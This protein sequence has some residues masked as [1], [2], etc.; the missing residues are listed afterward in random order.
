MVPPLIYG[1][2]SQDWIH[3]PVS[4]AKGFVLSMRGIDLKQAQ[5]SLRAK[6]TP[7]VLAAMLGSVLVPVLGITTPQTLTTAAAN[8]PNPGSIAV[9][10]D[11]NWG[12]QCGTGNNYLT[13]EVPDAIALS[14]NVAYTIEAWVKTDAATNTS[15]ATLPGCAEI[16]AGNGI[17]GRFGDQDSQEV[18]NQRNAR[19][20]G[21]GGSHY[22]RTAANG[23][24]GACDGASAATCT[25]LEFPNGRWTHIALQKSVVGSDARLTVFIGGKVVQSKNGI[26]SPT[27]PLKVF[28]LGPFGDNA[29][30]KAFYGQMRVSSG[31]IY[32]TDGT[33]AF[34]P[35][36]DFSTTV[37]GG[38]VLAL[39][40]PQ[41]NT[42]P[43]N[44]VDLMNNNTV[45]TTRVGA[46]KIASSSDF[47]VPSFG[48]SG[49]GYV[50]I[51][52]ATSTT[53][54]GC[55]GS[56]DLSTSGITTL[57]GTFTNSTNVTEVTLPN[58]LQIISNNAFVN[59]GIAKLVLPPSITSICEGCIASNAQL[60]SVEMS[61]SPSV[62][63]TYGNRT[64]QNNPVL[65][66]VSF[67]YSADTS[68]NLTSYTSSAT[69]MFQG[70]PR[71][72][73]V[74]SCAA[75][76]S[77]LATFLA[78]VN[79]S[80]TASPK[81]VNTFNGTFNP[82]V[83]CDSGDPITGG[84]TT[85]VGGGN[86]PIIASFTASVSGTSVTLTSG[87][88][89]QTSQGLEAKEWRMS[90]DNYTWSTICYINTDSRNPTN[91][92]R[93]GL[94]VGETYYFRFLQRSYRDFNQFY[95]PNITVT[96]PPASTVATLSNL[97]LSSG[98]LSPAFSSA[99][100]NYTATVD[101][102]VATGYAVTPT[103]TDAGANTVQYLGATGTTAFTGA[104]NIG[105]NV[106]R[107]VVT[108]ADNVT[109]KTYTVTVTRP[110]S[111]V[112]TL[113]GLVLSS[114]T[115]SP[116]FNS[117]TTSYTMSVANSVTS[118]TV[119][120]TRTQANATITVNGTPVNSGSA[121]GAISLNVGTNNITV[122]VT[123]QDG[124]TTGTYTVVVTRAETVITT[125][126]VL[127]TA[128]AVGATP[129]TSTTS[130]GQYTTCLLYTSPSP[131]DRQKSRMPSSA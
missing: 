5:L 71:L 120:P 11:S 98:T 85:D 31:A 21:G 70:N 118:T 109:T 46:S 18:W 37:S 116:A 36:L 119:T 43:S 113:S 100:E 1:I 99:T 35:G 121:S 82:T 20:S 61:G 44:A 54:V 3:H 111:T 128:P 114:V 16:G 56:V 30:G 64:F 105:A 23:V 55:A 28:K 84:G 106:I 124:S 60:T 27:N 39:F 96:V 24:V 34:T 33:S 127:I 76:D 12:G 115:L 67:G 94:T 10:S 42:L 112:A 90:T 45:I 87:N 4:V 58:T 78:G 48:C 83:G 86:F 89:T 73:V 40:K 57:S 13:L 122:V 92:V 130:N 129:Q 68:V 14:G 97:A 125:A 62:P 79:A 66:R 75:P 95:S 107:T 123:A 88:I 15:W 102:S 63:V 131:R 41:T 110:G 101:N 22:L 103:K 126:N 6:I 59:T 69:F 52:S 17:P 104:L 47:A 77:Y 2:L 7:I 93:N 26:S 38:T 9:T 80:D 117:A 74:N 25:N 108:A 50:Q 19:V 29:A 51:N 81:R 91:C 72:T 32:P 49:G 8:N 65:E 53:N